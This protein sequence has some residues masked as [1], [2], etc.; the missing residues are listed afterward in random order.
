[1]KIS[2]CIKN[3]TDLG[4]FSINFKFFFLK[5]KNLEKN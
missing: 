5:K 3:M 4:S 2:D 1:M